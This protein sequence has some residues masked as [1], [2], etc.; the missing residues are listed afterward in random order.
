MRRPKA[1]VS[2]KA[3]GLVQQSDSRAGT[4]FC[5]YEDNVNVV[6]LENLGNGTEPA[7]YEYGPF[8]EPI[9]VTG[10][11]AALNPFR[12]S[13]K[14]TCNTTDQVLYEYRAYSSTVG[15]WPNRDP[16]GELGF[17]LLRTGRQ[18]FLSG[19]DS[20]PPTP[21]SVQEAAFGLI[22]E[23]GLLDADAVNEFL[24]GPGGLNL[25]CLTGNDPLNVTDCL[26]L[27]PFCVCIRA[28]DDHAWIW[29]KDLATG[30][31]HT[32]GRWKRGYGRPAANKSGVLVDMEK[33][34]GYGA[35]R[36]IQVQE[37]KPTINE[38]YNVYNNN[39][40]TYAWSEWKRVSGEDLK[41]S[42]LFGSFT[43]DHPS[44]LK[45]SINKANAGKKK[46]DDCCGL[47]TR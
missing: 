20:A 34:R 28:D 23:L 13:T 26:G 30:E 18:I 35:S 2:V 38:G 16:I 17:H 19:R 6:A 29:V 47:A 1:S 45:D 11:A 25:Y 12:F 46:S 43:F 24:G 32:Y 27:A 9:R 31:V 15:R 5:A 14:R 44:V 3:N 42:S 8:A 40:A 33:N 10:P 21:G 7:R 36:C 41:K 37:F 4:G 22:Q 39:C